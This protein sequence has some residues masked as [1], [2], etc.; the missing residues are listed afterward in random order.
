MCGTA[1]AAKGLQPNIG[2]FGAEPAGADDAWQ[3]FHA[4]KLIPQT[5]PQTIAD[6]LRT[7]LSELTFEI[8]RT[9]LDDLFRVSETGIVEAMRFIWERMK[10]IVEPSAAVPVAAIREHPDKFRGK[11]VGVILSGGNVDLRNLPWL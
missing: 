5:N 11:T 7:S 2:V 9:H 8:I 4:G 3:S 1:I 10:I 6:G